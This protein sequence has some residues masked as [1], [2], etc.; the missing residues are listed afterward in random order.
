[1]FMIINFINASFLILK[2]ACA[3]LDSVKTEEVK[4]SKIILQHQPIPGIFA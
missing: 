4:N 2:E 3:E 1:M